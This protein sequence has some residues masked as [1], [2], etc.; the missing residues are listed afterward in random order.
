[1]FDP[2][3]SLIPHIRAGRLIALATT[4]PTRSEALP[5]VSSIGE[6]V[7]GYEARAWSGLGAPCDT[8]GGIVEA[9]NGAVNHGLAD[10]AT[11]V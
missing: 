2:A 3:H 6:F 1:M 5:D 10:Q 8:P 7:P 11:A 4:G 9:L